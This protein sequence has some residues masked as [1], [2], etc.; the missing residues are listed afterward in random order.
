MIRS[1][2]PSSRRGEEKQ[3]GGDFRAARERAAS[4]QNGLAAVNPFY[5]SR[6]VN[7]P[8]ERDVRVED[9]PG[10]FVWPVE[11]TV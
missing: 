8:V 5:E 7:V 6:V 11:F 3:T 2:S 4:F 9:D 1:P 10:Y